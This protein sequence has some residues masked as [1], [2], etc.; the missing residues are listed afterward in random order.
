MKLICASEA[1]DIIGISRVTF[2]AWRKA[3]HAPP[4]YATTSRGPLWRAE[5]VYRWLAEQSAAPEAAQ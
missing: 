4:E 2:W 3:G 5:D 1:A